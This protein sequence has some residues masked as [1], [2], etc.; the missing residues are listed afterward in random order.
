MLGLT[1]RDS[2]PSAGFPSK[3]SNCFVKGILAQEI[4]LAIIDQVP[5]SKGGR[6]ENFLLFSASVSQ[7]FSDFALPAFRSPCHNAVT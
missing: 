2:E 6:F 4:S 5:R 3:R 7:S 1:G